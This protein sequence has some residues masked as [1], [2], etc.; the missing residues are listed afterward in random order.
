MRFWLFFRLPQSPLY[1]CGSLKT[2]WRIGG[3]PTSWQPP[4]SPFN[5]PFHFQAASTI[6]TIGSLKTR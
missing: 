6:P 3:L 4:H 5:P 1:Q 2:Q